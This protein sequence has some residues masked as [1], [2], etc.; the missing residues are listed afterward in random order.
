MDA[1]RA[2][3]E[4]IKNIPVLSFEEERRLLKEAQSGNEEAR[5]DLIAANL[6]LVVTIAKHYNNLGLPFMDLIAEGNIGLIRAVEKFDLEK[7]YRF[8]TYA[9]WWIKQSITR[10]LVDQGKTI[11]IPVYMSE[12]MSKY[13]KAKEVLR[14]KN[15]QEPQ[16]DDIAKKMKVPQRKVAEI[17]LWMRSKTS[18]ETPVGDDG[19]SELGDFIQTTGSSDTKEVVDNIFEHEE[20]LRMLNVVTERERIVLDLRFGLTGGKTHTLAEVADE[21]HISRERVR[22]IE[23]EA[24]GKLRVYFKDQRDNFN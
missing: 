7:E 3:L 9:T 1:V 10:A 15:N 22:Q 24:I 17:E 13:R 6:K 19:A 18:L 21:L 11:R 14:Q 12:L 20:V 4:K 2:Y 8:S 5:R 23:Q 16:R